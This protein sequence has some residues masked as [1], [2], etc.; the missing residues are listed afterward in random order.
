MLNTQQ[1]NPNSAMNSM[2][3]S[4]HI[5]KQF[6]NVLYSNGTIYETLI[7]GKFITQT[8][9]IFIQIFAISIFSF[10]S[11]HI[12]YIFKDLKKY[13]EKI[14]SKIIIGFILY[15]FIF[16]YRKIYKYINNEKQK[17]KIIRNISLITSESKRNGQLFEI[18]QWFISSEHC[19]KGK[20]EKI[21]D[22]N[23]K[24]DNFENKKKETTNITNYVKIASNV[25]KFI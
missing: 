12:S 18:I 11:N 6:D 1:F 21:I 7:D 15:P 5:M 9:V 4:N 10:F 3:M 14:I 23:T 20:K 17:Y 8:F 2:M 13:T 19:K 24:T 16:T 25:Y 22:N